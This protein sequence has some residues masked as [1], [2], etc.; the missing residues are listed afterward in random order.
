METELLVEALSSYLI[1]LIKINNLPLLSFTS[2]VSKDTNCL[3]F[4]V[5]AAF[6]IKYL[7]VGPVNELIVL[8]FEYLE[9]STVGAPDLHVIG[10]TSTLDIP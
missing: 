10:F 1:S 9:P 2:V 3:T 6:D 7:I 4:F 5:L 8:V